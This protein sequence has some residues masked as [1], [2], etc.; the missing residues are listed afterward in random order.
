M[1]LWEHYL[2]PLIDNTTDPRTANRTRTER[3]TSGW[4]TAQKAEE[5]RCELSAALPEAAVTGCMG[6][7]SPAGTTQ[8]RLGVMLDPQGE[9]CCVTRLL[10]VV[11]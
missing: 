5:L 11:P 1:Q 7:C 10:G 9:G 2:M 3:E 4:T 6:Q 8:G